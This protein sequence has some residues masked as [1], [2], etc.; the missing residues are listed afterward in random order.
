[1]SK[2]ATILLQLHQQIE[3]IYVPEGREESEAQ[4]WRD[5]DRSWSKISSYFR[6]EAERVLMVDHIPWDRKISSDFREEGEEASRVSKLSNLLT[7]LQQVTMF[8]RWVSKLYMLSYFVSTEER[9][10]FGFAKVA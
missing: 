2:I 5:F 8:W 7:Q 3:L 10:G 6:E 9:N 1:M 4:S